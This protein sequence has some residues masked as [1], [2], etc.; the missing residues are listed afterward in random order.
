VNLNNEK[1]DYKLK[2]FVVLT[3]EEAF[4]VCKNNRGMLFK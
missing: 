1:K 2:G 4:C 3:G